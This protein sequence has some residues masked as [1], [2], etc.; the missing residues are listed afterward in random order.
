M[1][2]HSSDRRKQQRSNGLARS[3]ASPHLSE[4]WPGLKTP[5]PD[6]FLGENRMFQGP[7]CE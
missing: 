7:L 2:A 4:G 5:H 3:D 6:Q 1:T